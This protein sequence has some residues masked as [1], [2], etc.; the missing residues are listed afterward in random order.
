VSEQEGDGDPRIGD[1]VDLAEVDT[2]VRLDAPGHRLAE[3]V[4]TGDVAASLSAVL[5]AAAGSSGAGFFVVGPFGSGKS[6][7]LAAL[8]EL[9][10]D[11]A[12]AE[13]LGGWDAALCRQA[14]TA[15][16][17]L[18]VGVPL[19]EYRAEARLEDVVAQRAWRALEQP[20]AAAGTDRSEAWDRLLS[21]AQ[22]AGHA[23]VALLLD[24]LSEFLRAKQGPELTEDLR[25]LQFLGE[26]ARSRPVLV[27]AALQESIEEVANVSQRELT[28]IRDRYRPSLALSMRHVEDLVR[29]RLVRLRPG[30]EEWVARAGA[31]FGAAFPA[32]RID[33][34]HFARCYPLHPD[35]LRLLEGLRFLLSQQRGVVDF[36]CRQV[37]ADLHQP[38]DH[39]VT[40]D[41][42]YDHFRGRLH[43]RRETAGLA[44]TVVPYFERAAGEVVD[45]EDVDLALRAVKLCCLLA[46]SPLERPREAAELAGML[47]A[48]VSDVEPSANVAYLEQAVL[49]P[50][51]RRGA[52]LVADPGP[53][54]TYRVEVGAD[55]AVVAEGRVA[56]ARAETR[57]SDRRVVATL[58][59]LG[60]SPTLPLQLLSEVGTA[61]REL[62]W[63]NTLR[64]VLVATGRVMEMTPDDVEALAARAAAAGAEG[65][66]LVAE[67][68]PG[69]GNEAPRRARAL[70]GA[71]DRLVAWVPAVPSEEEQSTMLD[72]HARGVV[73]D[74]ARRAGDEGIADVLARSAGADTARAR[75]LLRR[76]YFD[77]ELVHAGA[78]A[79]MDLPS[80]AG[81]A[82]ERQLPSL[83][84]P[85]LSGLHPLHRQ[86]APRGELVGEG[87]LRRLVHE[88]IA[89][90]HLSAGALARDQLRPLV[91]GYLVPLGLARL[92]ADGATMAPEPSKSLPVGEVLRV[93]GDAGPVAATDVA[94]RLA[95][96]PLG[97]SSPESIL[98]LNACVQAGLVEL[99]RGRSRLDEPFSALS[100]ADRLYPGELVEPVVRAGTEALAPITGAGPFEPWS[101]AVQRA[102]W[103]AA[104]AWLEARRE[105]L[106]Q[107]RSGLAAAAEVPA[108]A[109]ADTAPVVT[110]ADAVAALLQACPPEAAPATGLRTLV[111]AVADPD[112][113]L[114]SARR[115]RALAR[116]L[117]DDLRRVDEMVA[118]LTHPELVIPGDDAGLLVLRDAA[119]TSLATV[120]ELAAEDRAGEVFTAMSEL[121][122]A[123]RAAYSEGHERFYA[124]AAGA[125]A[126]AVRS[127]T[128]Y[129]S[130]AA[131]AAIRAVAVPDDKVKV[132]RAL[133]AALPAPCR[134]RVEMELAWK[135]R[136]ACGY[137]LGDATPVL[138]VAAMVAVAERG[139]SQY[140]AEL[141]RPET[142][143]RL[144]TAATDLDALSRDGLASSVRRLAALASGP[145]VA[146]AS[147]PPS[148]EV[149][150]LLSEAADSGLAGVLDDVLTGGQLIVTRDLADLRED[151]I[152]RRYPKRRLLELLAGWADPGGDLPA[153][154]FVEIVDSTE[155]PLGD[156]RTPSSDVP[157]AHSA[158]VAFIAERYPT[159]SRLLPAR[160]GA[161]AFWLAA[162]WKGRPSPPA[163]LPPG[164][165]AED[166]P[167]HVAAGAAADHPG[168]R[169]ELAE[170]D[171]RA[172][173]GSVLG[174]EIAGALSLADLPADEVV[175]A[176]TGETLLRH[177]LRLAVNE[178]LGR[179]A[180]DWQLAARLAP[181]GGSELVAAIAAHHA[182]V[183]PPELAS[184]AWCVDAAGHLADLERLL[185]SASDAEL[186]AELYPRHGAPV[187]ELLSRADAAAAGVSVVEPGVVDTMRVAA[188]RLLRVADNRLKSHADAGFP[189]SLALCD[190]GRAVVA[191][192][193]AEHGRVA[194]LLVDAM[195]ADLAARVGPELAHL[196]PQRELT[197]RWAVISEPTRTAEA[198]AALATGRP[199]PAGST[200]GRPDRALVRFAHLGYE[201]VT[202]VGADRDHN[203]AAL[204][205]LWAGGP[206][207]SVAV[208][209]AVDDRLHRTSADLAALLDEAVA[210]LRHRVLPSL[211]VIPGHVPVVVLAD[212]G[213]RENP[214]WG[215]GPDGRYVHGGTSLEECVVPVMVLGPSSG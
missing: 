110:D 120:F 152:G 119:L 60:S 175:D 23:G 148:A 163:W 92:R 11:P 82:F 38:Y 100:G 136:C 2:V 124:A 5:A 173:P 198:V 182:L 21:C 208:A 214:T 211:S 122:S 106:A 27:V 61:R 57:P 24:E 31:R 140:L 37:R 16:A 213:F 138:D 125:G 161:D 34:E 193:L 3:L 118:Y 149:E 58:S 4:L 132:D 65:C 93:V 33:A 15:R 62:L 160:Q 10:A 145:G 201:A 183:L 108:L 30:A 95:E 28:R 155:A 142:V 51:T 135:P 99:R 70:A 128:A 204:R 174:E 97:L 111:S 41:R 36:V 52:Y 159:L 81:V 130:L 126:E 150:R 89:A 42:V 43:E 170:L 67:V 20:P 180:G 190:V 49:A 165:L 196:L 44:D 192:L 46:A 168:A 39:L 187:H 215:H 137:S 186:V 139:V 79:P 76:L 87:L 105:E 64:S 133:A 85:L 53:P 115:L 54:A 22:A 88:V 154:G 13:R 191:P 109:G 29:G 188:G 74:A 26:W 166:G 113:L 176:I 80:I 78:A 107:A 116:F 7:F 167:L 123:Y 158:T 157:G 141:G 68:E 185:P 35:T 96:G 59:R 131:L 194:V 202:L 40:P 47:L 75:E 117:R 177:P 98:V 19:V 104:R 50:L 153:R 9:V 144:V 206:P 200:G 14:A 156:R 8:A 86:V 127:S 210:G 83:V 181:E 184:L 195:R 66:L 162:W 199:V 94:A 178:L 164:M 102:A 1:L 90:G 18:P 112:A 146:G 69:E 179:V 171:A 72:L 121:R 189:G 147:Q 91:E 56:Q 73:A 48:R 143:E 25:F 172:R 151:L 129:R 103:N 114:R 77:G 6:H 45:E 212:H 17:S 12:A 63:H 207:V 134:R 203:A 84:D 209:T 205:E 55:A 197:R 101:T 32:S 71:T 169:S